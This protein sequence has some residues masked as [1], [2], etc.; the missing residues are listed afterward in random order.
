MP[1]NTYTDYSRDRIGWFFGLTGWQLLT[2]TVA[3]IPVF[4]AINTQA[5]G[6]A[7]ILAGAWTV[8]E[9]AVSFSAETREQ[10]QVQLRKAG[11]YSGILDGQIGPETRAAMVAWAREAT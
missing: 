10:I 6:L 3:S 11:F 1:A 2:L 4:W 5:W 8:I 7:G 9:Q